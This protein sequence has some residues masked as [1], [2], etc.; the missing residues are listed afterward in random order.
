MFLRWLLNFSRWLHVDGC[1]CFQVVLGGCGSFLPS[2]TTGER[3]SL[4]FHV[5]CI[6]LFTSLRWKLHMKEI[7]S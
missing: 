6:F 7:I 1:R 4:V 2:V 3:S 5:I